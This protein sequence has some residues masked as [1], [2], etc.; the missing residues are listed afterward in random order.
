[1]EVVQDVIVKSLA[2][3][4]VWRKKYMIASRIFMIDDSSTWNFIVLRVLVLRRNR[5]MAF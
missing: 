4:E 1:M 3:F 2:I 5:L